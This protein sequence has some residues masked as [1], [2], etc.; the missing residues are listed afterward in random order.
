VEALFRVKFK[1]II[2]K[3]TIVSFSFIYFVVLVYCSSCFVFTHCLSCSFCFVAS[4][5]CCSLMLVL[6]WCFALALLVHVGGA[7]LCS[8]CCFTMLLLCDVAILWCCCFVCWCCYFVVLLFHVNVR[9]ELF[10]ASGTFWPKVCCCCFVLVI[11]LFLWLVWYFPFFLALCKLEV[12]A[13][14]TKLQTDLVN[15]VSFCFFFCVLFFFYN[16]FY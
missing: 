15:F 10:C 6:C 8:C 13:W 1:G 14:S 3:R 11:Y 2:I 4:H 12:R 9:V 7:T 5:W 16:F